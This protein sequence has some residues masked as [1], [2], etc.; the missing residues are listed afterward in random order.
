VDAVIASFP[1]QMSIFHV[2]SCAL[3]PSDDQD[4]WLQ[5]VL[6]AQEHGALISID[7]NCRP[8]MT[9]D[10]DRYRKGLRAFCRWLISSNSVMKTLSIYILSGPTKH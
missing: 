4:A 5:I 8:S 1:P 10:P 9:T 7:P 6:A 3:I 2:G